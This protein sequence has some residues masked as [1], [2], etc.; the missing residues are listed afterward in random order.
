MLILGLD[1][2]T[3]TCEPLDPEKVRPVEVGLALY[4]T[5]YNTVIDAMSFLVWDSSTYSWDPRITEFTGLVE[6][7][8]KSRAIS[9]H[10]AQGL[11][12]SYAERS[13]AIMAH[14]GIAFDAKVLA[15]ERDRLQIEP[16]QAHWID[17]MDVLDFQGRCRKLGHMAAELGFIN[18]FPHRALF[19]VLTMFRV[20]ELSGGVQKAYERSLLPKFLITAT[21][22]GPWTDGG[23]QR[24]IVKSLGFTWDASSKKWARPC[25][26]NDLGVVTAQLQGIPHVVEKV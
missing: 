1:F 26:E 4:D 21:T 16:L 3:T 2:E 22:V 9:P 19:D 15:K 14:N 5:D 25:Y 12:A 6:E 7:H 20:V 13:K 11:I 17:T 24:D 18:P 10:S 23:R 8:F